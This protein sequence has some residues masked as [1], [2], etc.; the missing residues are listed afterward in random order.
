MKK[1]TLK[2]NRISNRSTM[3]IAATASMA[4][5][6]MMGLPSNALAQKLMKP[7]ITTTTSQTTIKNPVLLKYTDKFLKMPGGYSIAGVEGQH[8]IY[9]RKAG[10]YYFYIDKATGDMKPVSQADWNKWKD[11]STIKYW[12]IKGAL[13]TV[14]LN[15]AWLKSNKVSGNVTLLGE[16]AAGHDVFKTSTGKTVYLDANTGDFVP[17]DVK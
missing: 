3:A 8:T 2:K 12:P 6:P 5:A 10:G 4:V 16:D 1:S 9:Y 13:G 14:K 11:V 7:G 17:V 15:D